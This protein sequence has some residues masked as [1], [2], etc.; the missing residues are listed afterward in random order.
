MMASLSGTLSQVPE[1]L[2]D[3]FRKNESIPQEIRYCVP[4]DEALET[5]LVENRCISDQEMSLIKHLFRA[6]YRIQMKSALQIKEKFGSFQ[7][8]YERLENTQVT[9]GNTEYPEPQTTL[10]Q[11]GPD[12][13]SKMIELLNRFIQDFETTE[14]QDKINSGNNIQLSIFL[15]SLIFLCIIFY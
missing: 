7:R 5:S 6:Q 1:Q 12:F 11:L 2:L 13:K 10:Q 15:F 4:F 3:V 9:L 8:V 14:C